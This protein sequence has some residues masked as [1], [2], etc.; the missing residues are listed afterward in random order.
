MGAVA[1]G[2]DTA[3]GRLFGFIA[4]QTRRTG[5]PTAPCRGGGQIA[6]FGSLL[7]F[8]HPVWYVARTV[9]YKEVC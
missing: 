5:G 9:H 8:Q 4:S 7:T 6:E 3:V 1:S 2:S